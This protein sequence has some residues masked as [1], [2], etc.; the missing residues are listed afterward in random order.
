MKLLLDECVD[1][2][3]AKDISG[4]E[5]NSVNRRG[6]SGSKNGELLTLAASEFDVLVT[7]DRNLA[8]QQNVQQFEISIVVLEARSNHL[9]ELQQL[10]P[11]LL[12]ALPFLKPGE[13]RR[14]RS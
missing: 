2:R 12:K 1:H 8:F 3:L 14:I 4:H 6:W 5:T 10:V 11:E 13:I 7:T 9:V